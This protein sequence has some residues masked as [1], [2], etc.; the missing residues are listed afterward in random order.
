MKKLIPFMLICFSTTFSFS[1]VIT[2]VDGDKTYKIKGSLI[3]EAEQGGHM[4]KT[5]AEFTTDSLFIHIVHEYSS[6]VRSVYQYRAHTKSF[7]NDTYS[8]TKMF[9]PDYKTYPYFQLVI[10]TKYFA[11]NIVYMIP[12]DNKYDQSYI[13]L[14][15]GTEKEMIAFR[16][17]LFGMVK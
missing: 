17:K 11:E 5:Y 13:E 9:F 16:D 2:V 3:G 14:V 8:E 15:F 4:T 10:Y 1:Q 7:S 12:P 6:S